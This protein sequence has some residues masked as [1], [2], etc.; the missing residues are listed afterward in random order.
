MIEPY[1]FIRIVVLSLGTTWTVMMVVR[2]V[3]F[4]ARWRRRL[5]VLGMDDRWWRRSMA[6]IALRTTVLDPWNLALLCLLF[7]LW[8]V[9]GL[10]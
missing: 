5:D 8:T 10:S 1:A 3:R 7:G 2:I 9:R 6:I 4:A